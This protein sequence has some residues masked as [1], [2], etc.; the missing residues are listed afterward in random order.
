MWPRWVPGSE[1]GLRTKTVL[2]PAPSR[3]DI[4]VSGWASKRLCAAYVDKADLRVQVLKYPHFYVLRALKCAQGQHKKALLEIQF[5]DL[6]SWIGWSA[7]RMWI[8]AIWEFKFGNRYLFIFSELRNVLWVRVT[9]FSW[10]FYSETWFLGSVEVLKDSLI[11]DVRRSV[12]WDLKQ[13]WLENC[14]IYL[15]NI[16][17]LCSLSFLN[18]AAFR[19]GLDTLKNRAR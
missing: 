3:Y 16:A 17:M 12:S 19:K 9:K 4:L 10:W 18:A 11:R 8:W 14:E 6:I 5:W 13:C 2:S 1:A 15:A 7:Q